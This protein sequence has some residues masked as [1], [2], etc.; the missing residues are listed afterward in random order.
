MAVRH[1]S[2]GMETN[3]SSLAFLVDRS[4]RVCRKLEMSFNL[5]RLSDWS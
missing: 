2:Y 4:S 3:L 1:C 5:A